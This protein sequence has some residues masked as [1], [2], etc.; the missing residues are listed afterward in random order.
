MKLITSNLL[1]M[2]NVMPKLLAISRR[3]TTTD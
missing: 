1:K 3:I 2:L